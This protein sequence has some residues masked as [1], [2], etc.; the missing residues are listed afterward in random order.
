MDSRRI[1]QYLPDPRL[2]EPEV[3]RPLFLTVKSETFGELSNSLRERWRVS[4]RNE[5]QFARAIVADLQLAFN[6]ADEVLNLLGEDICFEFLRLA[7]EH[8][9]WRDRRFAEQ[10]AWVVLTCKQKIAE[11]FQVEPDA[12]DV[13]TMRQWAA[14]FNEF[15]GNHI[16][17][18]TNRLYHQGLVDGS[19]DNFDGLGDAPH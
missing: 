9:H 16:D 15:L 11:T 18:E 13:H 14:N 4:R 1:I 19:R 12:E 6:N 3:L 10:K 2:F 8:S 7:C 17:L 5:R